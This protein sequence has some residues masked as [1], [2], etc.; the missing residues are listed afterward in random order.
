MTPGLL[1]RIERG[2]DE[3]SPQERR[4][5]DFLRDHLADLAFY[6]ATEVARLSGVSKATISRLYRRLGF[7][8]AEEL[9]DHVRG[10]RAA[11]TPIA[12][13][14]P[15]SFTA[16]LDRELANLRSALASPQL[17]P[18]AAL[19]AAATRVLV[20]GLRNSYPVALHLRQQ[21]AQARDRV[22]LAPL[23]GQSLGEELVSLA[24]DDVVV[25]VGFRRR[26]EAFARLV[27]AV[28]S[29]PARSVLLTDST[30]RR[31][32]SEVDH[33][34]ECPVDSV[35]AFDSYAAAASLVS[36]LS[37]AVLAARPREGRDRIAG[38]GAAYDRLGE[39]EGA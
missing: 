31:F 2:Y 16:H 7:G 32:A 3:L 19:I 10:L 21:L 5:A 8:S 30:G 36:V 4:A 27:A 39:L 20:I 14:A 18:A 38:I 17:E 12:P 28:L 25:L 23:P 24:P 1:A 29:G 37:A 33:L 34:L 6:N 22:E 15:L 13:D 35:S 26:P 9:R 11:G